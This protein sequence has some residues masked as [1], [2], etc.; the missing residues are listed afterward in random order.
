MT[1]TADLIPWFVFDDDE[2]IRDTGIYIEEDYDKSSFWSGELWRP[3][4]HFSVDRGLLVFK[5]SGGS[6]DRLQDYDVYPGV[7]S[8]LIVTDRMRHSAEAACS[9]EEV[10]F[11][12]CEI[13]AKNGECISAWAMHP[14]HCEW[15]ID[16]QNSIAEWRVP[17]LR[18]D[19]VSVQSAQSILLKENC[20]KDR[21]I[22]RVREKKSRI[23]LSSRLVNNI[24]ELNDKG[25]IF[26]RD[27]DVKIT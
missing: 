23:I 22:L 12:P 1:G 3:G 5:L 6:I 14:R 4:D 2:L 15:C 25:V 16:R 9:R 21:N 24:S 27:F 10:L 8:L 20:L 18:P 19:E 26:R 13:Y 17:S 7:K 11:Y